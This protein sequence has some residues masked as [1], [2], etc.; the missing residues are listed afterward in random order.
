M[1]WVSTG[2]AF[3][4]RK[5]DV[6]FRLFALMVLMAL[7]RV[8]AAP[9]TLAEFPFEFREG[10]LWLE[11]SVPQSQEQLNFLVDT[12]AGV[13]VLNL[14][15]AK[16]LGLKL[17]QEVMVR[18]VDTMIAGYW[19]QHISAQVGGVDLPREYLAVDLE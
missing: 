9:P 11:V 5:P 6:R 4:L 16:R 10:L 17:G 7:L 2:L 8:Q 14:N 13:S 15:T 12:G 3:I 1:L 18:G 19:R